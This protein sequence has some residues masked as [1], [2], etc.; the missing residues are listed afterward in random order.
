MPFSQLMPDGSVFVYKD[1]NK[2]AELTGSDIH[3]SKQAKGPDIS[4]ASSNSIPKTA[5]KINPSGENSSK[6]PRQKR[7]ALSDESYMDAVESGDTATQERIIEQRAREAGYNTPRL[8]HG[9]TSFGFTEFNREASYDR[10][11]IFSSDNE[12]VAKIYAEN[13]PRTKVSDRADITPDEYIADY[14]DNPQ[15]TLTD[16]QKSYLKGL[17]I[18]T[19]N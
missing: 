2:N 5:E 4:S 9:T 10:I 3:P 12:D 18:A 15:T 13:D 7:F 11:S 16:K 6:N 14:H 8:Y 17:M 1:V 19:P